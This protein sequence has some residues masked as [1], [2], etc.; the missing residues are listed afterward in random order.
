VARFRKAFQHVFNPL[1]VYCR[2][3][4]IGLPGFMARK[5]CRAYERFVF[6]L[7]P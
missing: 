3:K 4:D 1:H 2:L 7:L 6:R 5:M